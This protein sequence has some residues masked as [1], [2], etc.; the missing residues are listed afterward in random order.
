MSNDK[1]WKVVKQDK[2]NDDQYLIAFYNTQAMAYDAIPYLL[3]KYGNWIK[4]KD[5]LIVKRVDP[6]LIM[7]PV[8]T[9]YSHYCAS[10]IPK[11]EMER[12]MNGVAGAEISSDNLM[13][14]F[15]GR[16]YYNLSRM[17]PKNWNVV[18]I[19]ASYGA[20]SYLFKDHAK[21][22]AVE[23]FKDYGIDSPKVANFLAPGTVRSD[24]TAGQF[25]KDILPSLNLNLEKTFAICNYV[26]NWFGE[27][28]MELV[29]HNF[30][31]VFTFYPNGD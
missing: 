19:G 11:E 15:G 23:P 4:D 28:P 8:A 6:S 21:Y 27:K 13:C 12:V 18:D 14:G 9:D 5:E 30:Q 24:A 7:S 31:Y 3:R 26:P 1:T 29:R 17:I 22:I 20:Q 25:I 10:L 2:N 16:T